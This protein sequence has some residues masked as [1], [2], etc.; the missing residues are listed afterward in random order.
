MNEVQQALSE[1]LPRA[2]REAAMQTA[3]ELRRAS[4]VDTGRLRASQT[5]VGDVVIMED[6]G[7]ILNRRGKHAGWIERATN[8]EVR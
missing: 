8:A 4:P 5:A 2:R 6:Y 1:A 7:V 3:R